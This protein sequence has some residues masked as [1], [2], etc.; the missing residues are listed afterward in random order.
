MRLIKIKIIQKAFQI[1][2]EVFRGLDEEYRLEKFS[3]PDGPNQV[4][5]R[6]LKTSRIIV[7]G[8]LLRKNL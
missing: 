6:G 4:S 7:R 5:K 2:E 3:I 1:M 8:F